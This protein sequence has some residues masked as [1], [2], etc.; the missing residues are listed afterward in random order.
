MR[1]DSRMDEVTGERLQ[2]ARR[3]AGLTQRKLGDMLGVS[4]AAVSQ[5]ETGQAHPDWRNTR[6]LREILYGVPAVTPSADVSVELAQ[7][8]VDLTTLTRV[9]EAMG[10]KLD[11]LARDRRPAPRAGRA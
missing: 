7:L 5:W 6:R 9:V 10:K 4:G 11:G 3:N 1:D 8:R 2:Q